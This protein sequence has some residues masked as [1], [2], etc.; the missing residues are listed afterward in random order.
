MSLW[1]TYPVLVCWLL[2]FMSQLA[3]QNVN[4]PCLSAKRD[5]S[6]LGRLWELKLYLISIQNGSFTQ[7]DFN[8]VPSY[9]NT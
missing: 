7:N 9:D 6:Y 3:N 2:A 5:V 4:N 8:L 1:Y